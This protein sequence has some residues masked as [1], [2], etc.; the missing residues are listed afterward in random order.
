LRIRATRDRVVPRLLR[1]FN[2]AGVHAVLVLIAGLWLIPNIGLFFQSLRTP[3]AISQSGWWTVFG[4]LGSLTFDSY[5]KILSSAIIVRSVRNSFLITVP[6]TF[7][8][9]S[10]AALAGYAMA[11]MRFKG[12][13][14]M[15]LI[16]VALL[17]VPV[18]VALIPIAQIY[19]V[20][21]V[22]GSIAGLV[23]FHVGFG[24]PFGVFLLR[25][26]YATIPA[27][28]FEAARMDGAGHARI[29]FTIGLP[30]VSPA[31][32]SLAIFQFVWVWNNLLSAMVFTRPESA[33]LTVAIQ[34]QM[35]NFGTNVDIIAPAAFVQ[36]LVPLLV[37]FA[38]Q[39]FFVEGITGGSVK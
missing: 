2:H 22:F 38:F 7:L 3:A 34:Q 15:F 25:N 4:D 29:F 14:A 9:V 30:L 13:D 6:A 32:A 19:N 12:R 33:P 21:G 37:F 39:K 11:W 17:V 20:L 23:M 8:V 18:Q 26:M 35:R 31:I 16:V 28:L 24:L 10:L 5:R 1:F 27:P 36:L